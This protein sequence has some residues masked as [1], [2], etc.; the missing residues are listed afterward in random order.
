MC[1]SALV[2]G[3]ERQGVVRTT[4][5]Y[6]KKLLMC[7]AFE[8]TFCFLRLLLVSRDRLTAEYR[9]MAQVFRL[10]NS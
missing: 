4:K 1:S 3:K 10:S 6:E 7:T 8:K 9:A 2:P 5:H